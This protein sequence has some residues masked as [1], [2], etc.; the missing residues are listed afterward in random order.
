MNSLILKSV[1]I[2][3]LS[4]CLLINTGV[5]ADQTN[6][7]LENTQLLKGTMAVKELQDLLQ[8]DRHLLPELETLSEVGDKQLTMQEWFEKAASIGN[9]ARIE[10]D[11]DK[12]QLLYKASE[13]VY[14]ELMLNSTGESKLQAGNNLATLYLRQGRSDEALN[15]LADL[16]PNE[17]DGGVSKSRFY[18]NYAFALQKNGSVSESL[19]AYQQAF[20]SDPTFIQAAHRGSELALANA[21]QT[22]SLPTLIAFSNQLI[23]SGSLPE[24]AANLRSAFGVS[25]HANNTGYTELLKVFVRFLSVSKTP[26]EVFAKVWLPIINSKLVLENSTLYEPMKTLGDVYLQDLSGMEQRNKAA[27]LFQS[28]A[29]QPKEIS[30][31][32]QTVAGQFTKADRFTQGSQRYLAAWH[33]SRNE[34]I[35]SALYAINLLFSYPQRLDP[36]GLLLEKFIDSIFSGKGEAYLGNDWPNILRCH[37]VLG[38]IYVRKEEWGDSWNPRTAIFQLEYALK[39]QAVLE[40]QEGKDV[41]VPGLHEKLAI[42]YR[43]ASRDQDAWRSF[44]SAAEDAI[45]L[46]Q[47]GSARKYLAES[48]KLDIRLNTRQQDKFSEVAGK[49]QGQEASA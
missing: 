41:A 37:T 22:Q 48:A 28:W 46:Q 44:I 42:A 2:Q 6:R 19:I 45:R 17:I 11:L 29:E 5:T 34:N 8:A 43:G 31:L 3:I 13:T 33:V 30:M 10:K 15:T 39:A 26:P 21:E 23:T 36:N 14:K 38:T 16:Q 9:S 18:Y 35:K 25:W 4:L 40:E 12:Q 47:W 32:L 7:S 1:R 20:T 24:A 27:K 49:I